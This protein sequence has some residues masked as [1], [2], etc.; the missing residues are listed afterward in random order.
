MTRPWLFGFA[1]KEIPQ[2][3][4]VVGKSKEF[5]RREEKV[6]VSRHTGRLREKAVPSR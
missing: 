4:K 2:R 1:E 3:Q 6:H 5:I